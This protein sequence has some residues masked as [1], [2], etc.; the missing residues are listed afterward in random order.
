MLP[1]SVDGVAG[2]L[3]KAGW[4]TIAVTGG[5]WVSPGILRGFDVVNGT[6]DEMGPEESVR[7]WSASRPAD[8][9]FFLFLHTYAAH[10]PYGEKRPGIISRIPAGPS[11]IEA[12]VG[13]L[14]AAA[15]ARGRIGAAR[16]RGCPPRGGRSDA[17]R[18][19]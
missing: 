4:S 18:R 11:A 19:G 1:A 12:D 3:R 10:D 14:L 16:R 7:V 5:G 2:S 9:P 17:T 8:R 6:F 15:K 13:R